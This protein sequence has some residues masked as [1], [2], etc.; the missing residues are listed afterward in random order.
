MNWLSTNRD[1]KYLEMYEQ[2]FALQ[3]EFLGESKPVN[4]IVPLV[5][6]CTITYQHGPFIRQCLDSILMQEADFSFEMIIGEDGSTDGTREICIEYAERYPERIRLFLRDRRLSQYPEGSRILHFNGGWTLRAARGK[7]IAFCEGDDYWTD[8]SK[9]KR[10]VD[11]L[12][13]HTDYSMVAH[14]TLRVFEDGRPSCV[15]ILHP[16]EDLEVKDFL[17]VDLFQQ[18]NNLC[19]PAHTS[20]YVIRQEAIC[21]DRPGWFYRCVS[22]DLVI[23]AWAAGYGKCRFFNKIMSVRRKHPGSITNNKNVTVAYQTWINAFLGLDR[24]YEYRYRNLINH[25]IDALTKKIIELHCL[26]GRPLAAMTA[27]L[28]AKTFSLKFQMVRS[29]L[30]I[31]LS[32]LRS[33][34]A[35]LFWRVMRKLGASYRALKTRVYVPLLRRIRSIYGKS[36]YIYEKRADLRPSKEVFS[37]A[38]KNCFF[39][40][41][42]LNPFSSDESRLLATSTGAGLFSPQPTDSMTIGYFKLNDQSRQFHVVGETTLWCWQQGCRLRWHPSDPDRLIIYNRLV[43]GT[44]GAVIQDIETKEVVREYPFSLYDIDCLGKRGV[45]LNFSRLQRLRPG[46]GYRVLPDE[47]LGDDRPADDGVWVADLNADRKELVF[48][49]AELASIEPHPTMHDAEHYINHLSISPKGISCLFLHLWVHRP[50][51]KR[52]SR[53]FTFDLPGNN[54]RLLLKS[55]H[56]S[57]YTW[58]TDDVLSVVT[59]M[60]SRAEVRYVLC[61]KRTGFVGVTG[62]DTLREDGHQSYFADGARMITDTYPNRFRDQSL[63]LYRCDTDQL[64]TV[65]RFK[66]PHEFDGEIR[67]DLHPR[68]SKSERFVCMDIVRNN[69]RAMTVLDISGLE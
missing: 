37:V 26:S 45:T 9:L 11:F 6:I 65:D 43:D 46:Y 36:K 58:V 10:Q 62:V 66:I 44:Y 24:H 60:S 49:C 23:T 2:G 14:N 17:D 16:K 54:L 7:Y 5:S 33:R 38:G 55:G 42:D 3:E 63:L 50:S 64:S 48:S 30:S 19:L 28:A 41:Y 29:V 47:T 56:V 20:S 32:R 22:G 8:P 4:S 34:P 40:Y 27:A 25:K 31:C 52:F 13:T 57:H 12:E 35:R 67:C 53:L 68:L 59:R 39:G 61:H 18:R 1:R 51:K 15:A 69:F 21:K